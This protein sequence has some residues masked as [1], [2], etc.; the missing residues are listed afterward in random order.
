MSFADVQ[1]GVFILGTFRCELLATQLG[2][3]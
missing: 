1:R 3:T 2:A